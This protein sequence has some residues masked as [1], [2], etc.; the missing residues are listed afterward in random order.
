MLN[1]L[2]AVDPRGNGT[3][4]YRQSLA[5]GG[6]DIDDYIGTGN[7]RSNFKGALCRFLPLDVPEIR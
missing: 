7:N 5:L 6:V 1:A 3:Q 4:T 2:N